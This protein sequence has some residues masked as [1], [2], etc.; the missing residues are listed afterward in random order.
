MSHNCAYSLDAFRQYREHSASGEHCVFKTSVVQ[1]EEPLSKC[2]SVLFMFCKAPLKVDL[3]PSQ[4][5]AFYL[6][7][8]ILVFVY[9]CLHAHFYY[10]FCHDA[11]N[12]FGGSGVSVLIEEVVTVIEPS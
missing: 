9:T 3:K 4:V 8:F 1:G 7:S 5:G 2:I 12:L 11:I 6:C 10:I